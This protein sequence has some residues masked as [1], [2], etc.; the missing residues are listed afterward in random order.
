[1]IKSEAVGHVVKHSRHAIYSVDFQ[2]TAHGSGRL[3]TAGGDCT[4]KLWNMDAIISAAEEEED[5]PGGHEDDE[6]SDALL[7]T[8]SLHS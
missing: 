3:A 4:V 8:L 2:P 7:A 1:V 5:S 6:G